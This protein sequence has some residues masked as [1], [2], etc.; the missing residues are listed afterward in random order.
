MGAG[1]DW[2]KIKTEYITTATSYRKLAD[3]HG[4][5]FRT[6]AD[7]A[8]AE[9]WSA[10]RK[11]HRNDVVT[12]ALQKSANQQS[13]KMARIDKAADRLLSKLERAIDELDLV[14][15]MKKTKTKDIE[16]NNGDR[17]DKPTR[18]VIVEEETVETVS[19]MVDRAGLR[20]ITA[21]LK[22]L[23]EVKMLRS[24]LDRQEQEA[25]IAN[26]RRQAESDDKTDGAKLEIVGLPEEF[27]V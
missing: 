17:P 2:L 15:A 25:R 14:I 16:Y 11:K 10:A 26:L 1:V 13:D 21:A 7:R 8:K 5:P 20:M 19:A 6:L 3:K 4:V 24:E 12:K 18:E 27:K 9:G 22:D 23:K